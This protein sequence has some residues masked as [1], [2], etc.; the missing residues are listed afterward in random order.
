MSMR[1]KPV[2]HSN[3]VVVR[4]TLVWYIRKLPTFIERETSEYEAG[5]ALLNE[6]PS[7]EREA[8]GSTPGQT[9]T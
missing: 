8:A 6:R 5:L 9:N 1:G 3:G 7:A 2:T 4:A